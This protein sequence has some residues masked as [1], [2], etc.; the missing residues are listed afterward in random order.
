MI[1]E[2]NLKNSIYLQCRLDRVSNIIQHERN[3]SEYDRR[4]FVRIWKNCGFWCAK[5]HLTSKLN[6]NDCNL[7]RSRTI[8]WSKLLVRNF[9]SAITYVFHR[10]CISMIHRWF[11]AYWNLKM[12]FFQMIASNLHYQ[13]ITLVNTIWYNQAC[14]ELIILFL[15]DKGRFDGHLI[16]Y[17]SRLKLF[18]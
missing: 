5:F 2:R 13:E 18:T 4:H 16:K 11:L 10:M 9:C 12:K 14:R 1:V 7:V 8:T 3:P 6:Q 17:I 15:N